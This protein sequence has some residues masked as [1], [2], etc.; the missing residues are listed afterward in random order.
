MAVRK[1]R[2][3][4][5]VRKRREK[6]PRVKVKADRPKASTEVR[7]AR[8][9]I[10]SGS[11][12]KKVGKAGARK[13]GKNKAQSVK[14]AGRGGVL[15]RRQRRAGVDTSP[16]TTVDTATGF[17]TNLDPFNA[18]PSL[19]KPTLSLQALQRKRLAAAKAAKK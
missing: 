19:G 9:G 2:E 17:R 5:A 14:K 13:V 12:K 11:S 4:M 7:R 8:A 1:R 6:T 10:G 3:K 16:P 18:S 15:G